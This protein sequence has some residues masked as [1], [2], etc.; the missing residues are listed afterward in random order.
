MSRNVINRNDIVQRNCI[1]E[2]FHEKGKLLTAA[3]LGLA[4]TAGI[5]VTPLADNFDFLQPGTAYAGGIAVGS[6]FTEPITF[7][8]YEFFSNGW[9]Q[10][11]NYNIQI[12]SN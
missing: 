8:P 6:E 5:A 3:A 4:M 1:Y 11:S 7:E 2:F 10:V 9:G 12:T